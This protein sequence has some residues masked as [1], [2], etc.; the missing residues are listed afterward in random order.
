MATT[1]F[2]PYRKT[3]GTI[4]LVRDSKTGAY[5]TKT[6]GF[7]DLPVFNLPK[8]GIVE[9]SDDAEETKKEADKALQEQTSAAFQ[10][11]GGGGGEGPNEFLLP[12][13]RD[14]DAEKTSKLLTSTFDAMKEDET[15]ADKSIDIK[16]PEIKTPFTIQD[17]MPRERK[18]VT[19][20][21]VKNYE[22]AILRGQVGVKFVEKD[23]FGDALFKFEP[24][25]IETARG[26]KPV[27]GVRTSEREALGFETPFK[28]PETQTQTRSDLPAPQDRTLG[29]SA[30]PTTFGK[31]VATDTQAEQEAAALGIQ[32]PGV[33]FAR[34]RAGTIDQM[35][36]DA[37]AKKV[38][39]ISEVIKDF[40]D[41]NT[42]LKI[43]RTGLMLSGQILNQVGDAILGVTAVD[44]RRRELDSAAA[45]SLGFK[46]RGELG[47]STDPGR[48]AMSPAD[49]VLGGKNRD[50]ALGN[51]SEAGAKRIQTR[52]TTGISRV[53]KRYGKNSKQAQD[54]RE[55]TKTF[56]RQ[57]NEFNTEKEKKRKEKAQN[58][59][60]RSG[61]GKE[62][63]GT[64]RGKIVC[65]MMNESYGF[66][67]FRN[68]IWLRQS[69]NLA[70]EYQKGYHR[71]FLPL[72]KY[73]KQ[74][75]ITNK[76][77]KNILEHIAIHRT[78]DIRQEERNKIHLI[79]RIYR[80]ILE[81]ICYW[82]GRK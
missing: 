50:S 62:G 39:N 43:A 19:D 45:K 58:P 52:M 47:A 32:A 44:K 5:S 30:D 76:I 82:A 9:V 2:D 56:Q 7:A 4:E 42:S 57:M 74:K 10:S 48:I 66:G 3:G 28:Q 75:G 80:K 17:S 15:A 31:G 70:P 33:A 38:K 67:S 36:A 77:I 53:E 72:V 64:S 8:L 27:E 54:F 51:L 81:P 69:K 29:I 25:G 49:H 60:L 11:G 71:I 46:T 79:G 26:R 63:G 1:K 61:A 59:N 41:N 12:V 21:T 73:A 23:K 22:D 37:Q 34:P 20:V 55:K 78:I 14:D 13:D 6:V 16:S 68:K 24:K 35:A 40:T 65:T 18:D